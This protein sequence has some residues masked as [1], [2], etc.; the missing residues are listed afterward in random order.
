MKETCLRA[1][2]SE[3]DSDNPFFDD[4]VAKDAA[5]NCIW[6]Q[7]NSTARQC[8]IIQGPLNFED[9]SRSHANRQFKLWSLKEHLKADEVIVAISRPRGLCIPGPNHSQTSTAQINGT[10]T[11][12]LGNRQNDERLLRKFSWIGCRRRKERGNPEEELKDHAIIDSGCSESMTGDKDKLSDF[13]D[14]KG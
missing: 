8:T 2:C 5:N 10:D 14:Y 7:L 6:R 13:K 9:G 12:S 4:I 1:Q 3:E 11:Q